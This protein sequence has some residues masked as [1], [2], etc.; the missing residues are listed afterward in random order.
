MPKR[1]P[2]R[3]ESVPSEPTVFSLAESAWK[4]VKSVQAGAVKLH[5]GV[6]AAISFLQ[7]YFVGWF[8]PTDSLPAE[9]W[10]FYWAVLRTTAPLTIGL[11]VWAGLL[12]ACWPDN[13]E[14]GYFMFMALIGGLILTVA[15]QI[16]NALGARQVVLV[17]VIGFLGP[18]NALANALLS[19]LQ[20]YRGALFVSA[21]AIA[22]YAGFITYRWRTAL[23]TASESTSEPE[24]RTA[25]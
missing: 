8:D 10:S 23:T 3:E 20:A 17:D 24:Q 19:Y 16:G 13:D 22:G 12:V 15:A 6:M 9:P 11:A 18:A 25:A 4:E 5:V 14:G 1:K 2:P 21:V 7:P